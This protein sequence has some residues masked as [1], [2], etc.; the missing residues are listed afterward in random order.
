MRETSK[1]LRNIIAD[2]GIQNIDA[3]I[4]AVSEI[5]RLQKM[6]DVK[7]NEKRFLGQA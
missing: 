7:E 1:D 2:G 6:D 4:V 5:F 3:D